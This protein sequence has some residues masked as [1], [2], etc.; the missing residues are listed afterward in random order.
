MSATVAALAAAPVL[1]AGRRRVERDGADLIVSPPLDAGGLCRA[2]WLMRRAAAQDPADLRAAA[3]RAGGL[4]AAFLAREARPG[5]GPTPAQAAA[6]A[7]LAAQDADPLAYPPR[8]TRIGPDG[9]RSVE[10]ALPRPDCADCARRAW[11]DFGPAEPAAAFG[12]A[13]GVVTAIRDVP[14]PPGEV[15]APAVAIARLANHALDPDRPFWRGASGK[16]LAPEAARLGALC[17]AVE[18][19]AAEQSPVETVVA[20]AHELDATLD[21]HSGRAAPA[22]ASREAWVRAR[23]VGSPERC[24]W[25]TARSVHLRRTPGAP[26]ATSSGL[27]CA[28]TVEAAVASALSELVERHLFL[29]VWSGRRPAVSGLRALRRPEALVEACRAAGVTLRAAILGRLAGVFVAAAV[30]GRAAATEAGRPRYALGLGRGRSAAEAARGAALEAAQ[31]WRGL[32]WALRDDD[33]AARAAALRLDPALAREP[34]D[35]ALA[36]VGRDAAT[37]P[38]P[39]GD[40]PRPAAAPASPMAFPKDSAPRAAWV[41]LTPPD[42]R[43]ATGLHVVRVVAEGLSPVSFGPGGT[44]ADLGGGGEWPGWLHPLC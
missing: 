10:P 28:G 22:R 40:G 14:A 6:A 8:L 36:W 39:F 33:L 9:A 26:P 16:A 23:M 34:Y 19:Y 11:R 15:E 43:R 25:V 27:A 18:R 2:C 3:P 24:V 42:I 30:C 41:D 21:P 44:G 29:E 7:A 4:V 37:A 12:A 17:E 32:A 38:S 1:A 35:H 20:A 31:V 5:A 13:A